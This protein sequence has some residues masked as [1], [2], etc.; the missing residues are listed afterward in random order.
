MTAWG[1][2]VRASRS[3]RPDA[4]R[5]MH[6][7]DRSGWSSTR[8][9]VTR[10]R[11]SP[12]HR[13]APLAIAAV[14]SLASCGPSNDEGV[15]AGAQPIGGSTESE[16]SASGAQRADPEDLAAL[17]SAPAE[18][19]TMECLMNLSEFMT[20]DAD[21]ALLADR[22]EVSPRAIVESEEAASGLPALVRTFTV[23]DVLEV[24][25]FTDRPAPAGA[26]VSMRDVEAL[27]IDGFVTPASGFDYEQLA[28]ISRPA[29]IFGLHGSSELPLVVHVVSSGPEDGSTL[30]N[31]ACSALGD[32]ADELATVT[33]RASGLTLLRDWAEARAAGDASVFADAA[34]ELEEQRATPPLSWEDQD[35][36]LR[37]LDP[38]VVP[39][40]LRQRLDARMLFLDIQGLEGDEIFVIR[41]ATGIGRA[42]SAGGLGGPLPFYYVPDSDTRLDLVVALGGFL[43][44]PRIVGSVLV[45]DL[46][47]AGGLSITGDAD[48]PRVQ[49]LSRRETAARL[50]V[51]AEQLEEI[52]QGSLQADREVPF[53]ELLLDDRFDAPD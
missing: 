3:A 44:E 47:A 5:R 29:L 21:F 35:P 26:T 31:S 14:L 48:S 42:V 41:S 12:V 2:F 4:S 25:Q 15:V 46:S 30:F 24:H 1:S 43:D 18:L 8:L 20:L 38:A 13:V 23:S 6:V 32:Q 7:G 11:R 22:V 19:A 45:E 33:G 17:R 9:S 52:R 40:E 10:V 27:A 50:D 51:T 28:S 34:T 49:I 16:P 53:D 37:N 39:D 36:R